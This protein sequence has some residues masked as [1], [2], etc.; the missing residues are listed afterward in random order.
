LLLAS[1]AKVP[2]L[3]FG[4]SVWNAGLRTAYAPPPP[5]LEISVFVFITAII[6][7]QMG[8]MIG[9]LVNGGRR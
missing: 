2:T 3:N 4:Y 5:L 9:K 1:V 6:V 7:R 8:L